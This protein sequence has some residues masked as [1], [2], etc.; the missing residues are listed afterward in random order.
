MA[1][2]FISYSRKD[3]D[4]VR[5]LHEALSHLNRDT[6]V[7]WEDIPPTA[8]WLRE[9]YAAIEAAYT[10]V[11]V[12]SP[13]SVSSEVCKQEVAHAVKYNKRIVPIVRRDVNAKA[14]P[15]PLGALNWIFFREKDE[16]DSACQTLLRALDTDLEWVRAHTRLLV[17]AIEWD[18]KGRDNSFVLR[19]ND[20]H[21]AEQ[22]LAQ[23]A[24]KEP[25]PTALQT[26]YIITSRK[27]AT[28]RQRVTL[29]AVT[30][31][32]IVAIVLAVVAFYHYRVAELRLQTALSRQLSAQAHTHMDDHFDLA[33]LISL[34][35]NYM[36]DT[37]EAR[38]SLLDVLEYSPYLTTYL[39]GHTGPVNT[40]AFS[41][42]GKTLA[43]GSDDNTIKLWDVAAGKPTVHSLERH[44]HYV[45]SVAFSPNG[46]LLAS[47]GW[48]PVDPLILWDVATQHFTRPPFKRRDVNDVAFNPDGTILALGLLD[49]SIVLW[50]VFGGGQLGRFSAARKSSVRG[51]GLQ[52]RWS[53]G[54]SGQLRR[55]R[56]NWSLPPRCNLFVGCRQA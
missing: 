51:V 32:L 50:D 43:S 40:V 53:N 34:Q 47:G 3:R 26:Q 22:W 9:I 12:I 1:D 54:G 5:V 16:F 17:R 2:V 21:E 37:I 6:W 15:E 29:G 49:G 30:F 13:D 4:F 18:G 14:V 28:A 36:K 38:G 46:R 39:R 48:D 20:L 55:N 45:R 10:F 44:T 41:P 33:L 31:G 19:G 56:Y 27:A 42:D 11:F 25:K 24:D 23:G 35:A 52:S 7:D 8:E